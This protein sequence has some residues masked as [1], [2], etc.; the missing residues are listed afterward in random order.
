MGLKYQASGPDSYLV[1]NLM[2]H[3]SLNHGITFTKSLLALYNPKFVEIIH[4][5]QN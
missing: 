3:I 2:I 1:F 5:Q 4:P